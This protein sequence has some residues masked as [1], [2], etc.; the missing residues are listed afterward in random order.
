MIIL[1]LKHIDFELEIRCNKLKETFDK[2][3]RKQEN[4][5][6]STSYNFSEGELMLFDF[7]K[8]ELTSSM[9][10][11][12]N[13]L[14]FENKDYS[15]SFSFN[16]IQ[17]IKSPGVASKLLEI[18]E[19]FFYRENL[20]LLSGT[21]NFGNNIGKSDI[22]LK[23][24]KNGIVKE[25]SFDFEV[26]PTKLNYKS[27]YYKMISD[28]E[29]EY[30]YLVLD[31]L[32]KTYSSFKTGNSPNTDL[33]WWQVFGGLYQDF[34]KASKYILNKP[35]SRIIDE[36][37]YSKAEQIIRW[38]N[39]LEEEFGQN[40]RF[41]NK[42][43]RSEFKKLSIN[44]SE[45]KF[46]KFAVFQ[47]YRRFKRVKNFIESKYSKDTTQLFKDELK[48]IAREFE[49]LTINPFFRKIDGYL[50][51]KQESLVLQKATGYSTIYK[52]W[53]MLNS[54][55]KF[56]EGIQRIELK[57]V[58]DLYQ[59]WCF[60][61][62]KNVLQKLLGKDRPDQ[63]QLAQLQIDDFVFKF[64]RGV[65]SKVSFIKNG[66]V[67]DL[68]HD[69]KYSNKSNNSIRSFTVNQKPDIVLR[70]TKNDLKE[71]YAMTYLFDAKYRLMSDENENDI[72]APPEDAI[73]QMHR[74]R[75][76]IYYVNKKNRVPEKEVIGGYVLFPG[77]GNLDSIKEMNY[78][79]SIENVNIGAFPLRPN[80]YLN[81]M[82]LE[83][84]LSEILRNGTEKV[85]KGVSP[86]KENTYESPN[87]YVLIGIVPTLQHEKC[88]NGN[89]NPFYYTGK[90][91][92]TKFGFKNLKYFAPYIKG[93]GVKSY[94]EI[95]AYEVKEREKIF[96]SDHILYKNDLETRLVIWLGNEIEID[97]GNYFKLK[98]NIGKVPYRYTNLKN[99][100]K[101]VEEKIKV[102]SVS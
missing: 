56:M 65:K 94:F 86:Q 38:T 55:L 2:A 53:I 3:K 39:L 77:D 88:F 62:I 101:P 6:N 102:L 5:N 41:P 42:K 26:F 23:Y 78:F 13:P 11:K 18:E 80:D 19:K 29:N 92:P 51:M 37:K 32:K 75:D 12:S 64:E 69:F 10:L 73:N 76:A 79:K 87:P 71:K 93:K 68:Y 44:T 27:D 16:D 61:E 70:V 74:Y 72:D 14:I 22:I 96:S 54:G 66:D 58:A 33:I 98:G 15:I 83:D 49:V 97:N 60:L 50:G 82:L 43:Y 84:H 30:P 95:Q 89:S 52:S 59:I 1:K 85:L 9:G 45:N 48:L 25:F 63:V 36:V 4:I 40:R 24:I 7:E 91:K 34:L 67:I 99:I 100:R 31:F 81:S 47:T 21:L 57:N 8:G 35:H 46:F 17:D 90:Q 28:I 20:R